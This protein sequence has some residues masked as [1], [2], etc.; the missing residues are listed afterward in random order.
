MVVTRL[1]Y[2]GIVADHRSEGLDECTTF[3]F[4]QIRGHL[5]ALGLGLGSARQ[6]YGIP[7]VP[8]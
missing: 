8:S 3:T 6:W 7:D 2:S 1:G 4:V 5:V